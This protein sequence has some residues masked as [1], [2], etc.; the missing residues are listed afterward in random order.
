M[1]KI[2][3]KLFTLEIYERLT[4]ETNRYA[5][6]FIK[7]LGALQ[8]GHWFH[9]WKDVSNGY[10]EAIYSRSLVHKPTLE[11]YFKASSFLT[12]TSVFGTIIA[13]IQYQLVCVFLHFVVKRE[14]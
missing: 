11:S 4:T 14:R 9:K 1:S 13:R 6:S 3:D 10:N 8:P 12:E 7:N 5:K 2:F